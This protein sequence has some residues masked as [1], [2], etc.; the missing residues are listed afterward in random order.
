MLARQNFGRRHQRSLRARFDGVRHREQA[1]NRLPDPTSPCRSLSMRL[2]CAR[3][4]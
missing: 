3:S 1:H 4:A 2:G